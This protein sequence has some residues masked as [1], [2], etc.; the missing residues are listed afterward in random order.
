M[1]RKTPIRTIR[2]FNFFEEKKL[3]FTKS[4]Y[5]LKIKNYTRNIIY[6][7]NE[8]QVN[9]NLLC[10]FGHF[11]KKFDFFFAA[12]VPVAPKRDMVWYEIWRLFF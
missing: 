5:I 9:S 8:R 7:K 10:K 3:H 4:D 6:A 2:I 12:W 11:L 1:H